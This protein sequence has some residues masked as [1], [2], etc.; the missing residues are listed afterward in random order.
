MDEMNITIKVD[1]NGEVVVIT[2]PETIGVEEMF[3]WMEAAKFGV[4]TAMGKA[5]VEN[6]ATS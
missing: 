2:D 1:K 4:L 3:F 6:P 5:E